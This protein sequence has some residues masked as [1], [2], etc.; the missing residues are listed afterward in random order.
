MAVGMGI[1]RRLRETAFALA[2]CLVLSAPATAGGTPEP[3]VA[4]PSWSPLIKRVLPAVV[5]VAAEI[6]ADAVSTDDG[7]SDDG[8]DGQENPAE[9]PFY[10]FLRRYFGRRGLPSGTPPLPPG[11]KAAV[12]G[13]IMSLGSAFI[14]DPAGYIVTN[15]HVVAKATKITVVFQDN[16][17]HLAEVVGTDRKIDIALLKVSVKRKLPFVEWGDSGKVEAGDWVMTVGNPFGLGGT[18]TA[19]IVSAMGRDLQQG[20]FDDFLQIDAPIN[21][22]NSGGPT[23]DRTGRVVGINTAIYSPSG[24][25]VGIGFA[26]PSGIAKVIV[27]RLRE[28]GHARHGY[29][30]IGVQ[31]ISPEIARVLHMDPDKPQGLLINEVAPDSPAAK[32]GIEPGDVIKEADGHPVQVSHD[33]SILVVT[34]KV[35]DR[36]RMKLDR[37][38]AA[39]DVEVIVGQTPTKDQQAAQQQP[40]GD[41]ADVP[42]VRGIW[43]ASLTPDL[44]RE[45]EL[46]AT[47]QGVAI[48]GIQ[49]KSPAAAIGLA[50]GD[51]IASIDRQVVTNPAEAAEKLRSAAEQGDVLLLVN[52]HGN[53]KFMVLPAQNDDEKATP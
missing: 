32:A 24:G 9:S 23:F 6:P 36:L 50:P 52:R 49:T 30:G 47:V 39:Q 46:T 8:A 11:V 44:R 1:G 42:T 20:P 21:R 7:Q 16:S 38:G 40:G 12:N 3:I 51:V 22:G 28:T 41:A 5:N 13:K 2:A 17:R 43:F 19:G 48:G 35:G 26:I 10:D 15:Y 29:L 45:L 31:P 14:I 34:A 53:A 25:S 37:N 27:Q 18:V 33:V 4:L